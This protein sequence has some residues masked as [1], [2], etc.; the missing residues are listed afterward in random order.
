MIGIY[1]LYSQA[2]KSAFAGLAD[3]TRAIAIACPRRLEQAGRVDIG[4]RAG[5]RARALVMMICKIC[6][7]ALWRAAELRGLFRGSPA[8]ERDGFI[9]F[10]TAAQLAETAAKHFAEKS[11]LVLV[12]VDGGALGSQLNWERSRG[13]DFFPHLY[14]ALPSTAVRWARPVPDEADGRRFLP[15]LAP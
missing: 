13:G 2:R 12:A 9:H 10:S 5:L 8:D 6:E 11:D 4:S 14:A 3:R 1:W 15:E 7:Q